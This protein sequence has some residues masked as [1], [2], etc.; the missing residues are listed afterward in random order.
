ML[1]GGG[2]SRLNDKNIVAPDVF[3]D[4]YVRLT[5]RERANGGLTQRRAHVFAD[6]LRKVAIGGAAKNFQFWLK[7]EHRAANL[8]V[9]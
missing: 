4:P 3:L 8:G 7:R 2:A 9:R 1:V 6:A 5:I